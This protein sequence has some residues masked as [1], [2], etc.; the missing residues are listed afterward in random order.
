MYLD[1]LLVAQKVKRKHLLKDEGQALNAG[2]SG[3]TSV[4]YPD[5]KLVDEICQGYEDAGFPRAM[6]KSFREQLEFRAW[7][8]EVKGD[9]GQVAAPLSMRRELWKIIGMMLGAKGATKGI[10]QQVLGHICF[11]LQFRRECYSLLH[12]CF[13]YVEDLAE[14]VWVKLPSFICDELR[15]VGCHL[16]FCR[17]DL[18]RRVSRSVVATDATPSSGGSTRATACT[19]LVHKLFKRC[20]CRGKQ[21]RLDALQSQELEDEKNYLQSDVIDALGESLRWRITKQYSFRETSHINLQELRAI[22]KEVVDWSRHSQDSSRRSI[23]CML[24]DSAV[25]IG[26]VNKGRS[27]SFKLMYYAPFYLTIS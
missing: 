24:C 10:L 12:H 4:E 14:G 17:S 6:K 16:P 11:C 2:G 5:T 23:H 3:K 15:S 19:A 7:G 8:A 9:K 1:D 21:L 13:K 27:S 22:K 18:R 26:A 25:V 20:C